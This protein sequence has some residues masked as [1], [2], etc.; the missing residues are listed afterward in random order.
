MNGE[1]LAPVHGAP[2]RV[3]VPGYIGA[4]SVKWLSTVTVQAE[5]S[6]NY[7]QARTYR[8]FPTRVRSEAATDEHGIALGELPVSSA[9]CRPLD[10]EAVGGAKLVVRGYAIT[11]G[12]RRIERVELSL[13]RGASFVAA[14]LLDG[15]SVGGFR[16]WEAELEVGAGPSEV[17][18]RAW[19]SSASTQPESAA[20]IW[21]LKGYMNNAWHRIGFTAAG[22]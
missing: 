20:Q 2:V 14:E 16:L 12:T 4:R 1:P 11:G 19:D 3:V 17:V 10:G 22:R 9:I 21:N 18:V 8:L 13:D 5:P 7:F 15:D 6:A